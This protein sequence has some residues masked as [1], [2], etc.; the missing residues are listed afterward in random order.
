MRRMTRPEKAYQEKVR[1]GPY[2]PTN[3]DNFFEKRY[4]S[5][6]GLARLIYNEARLE[7]HFSLSCVKR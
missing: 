3:S 4:M 6:N 5:R 2:Q 7:A 1:A